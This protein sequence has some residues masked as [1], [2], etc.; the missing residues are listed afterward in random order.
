M[1]SAERNEVMTAEELAAL[2]DDG[3]FY[4]LDSGRLVR[5][6][7][8]SSRSGVVTSRAHRRISAFVE[9]NDLGIC[10]SAEL[11]YVLAR[12][13]DRVRV[14]DISFVRAER[15]PA[16]GIPNAFWPGP[17]DLAVEVRSPTDRLTEVLRKIAD[18]L[19]AGKRL[20]WLIEPYPRR[21]TV[22]RPD[23]SVT[24]VGEDGVLDGE[25]VL[26]GFQLRLAEV[27]A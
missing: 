2:P 14:P 19:K 8:A 9:D 4:E 1:T 11:G 24:V 12:N 10:G 13:P 6:A 26:P 18:N 5:M 27:W 25:D 16:T 3:W 22:Y 21:A 17:P 20:V 23:G 15:I 7:P